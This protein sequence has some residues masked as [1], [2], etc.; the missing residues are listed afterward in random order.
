MSTPIRFDVDHY[1]KALAICR[2]ANCTIVTSHGCPPRYG[3]SWRAVP[4]ACASYDA[5]IEIVVMPQRVT[6][7]LG[8]F[9]MMGAQHA[10]LYASDI[11]AAARI[12]RRIET[13]CAASD[14]AAA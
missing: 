5:R 13:E 11:V 2:E 14:V 9:V 6:V 1:E 10:E 4:R 7:E 12:V 8:R 3:D